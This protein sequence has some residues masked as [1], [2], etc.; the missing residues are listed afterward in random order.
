MIWLFKT[1]INLSDRVFIKFVQ[2]NLFKYTIFNVLR[3]ECRAIID[4]TVCVKI[5]GWRLCS[6]KHGQLMGLSPST[7]M[8][9]S[10]L[11]SSGTTVV[12]FIFVLTKRYAEP[13][14]ILIVNFTNLN[15]LSFYLFKFTLTYSNV[16]NFNSFKLKYSINFSNV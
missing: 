3:M 15:I 12:F 5:N 2:L 16:F 14:F 6:C 8:P 11:A 4:Q 13:T 9:W 7:P 10:P 1:L